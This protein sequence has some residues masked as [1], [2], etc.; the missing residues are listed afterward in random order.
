MAWAYFTRRRAAG[1]SRLCARLSRPIRPLRCALSPHASFERL[2]VP[3]ISPISSKACAVC[4]SCS[5]K[6]W[7]QWSF[8]SWLW[9]QCSR[10]PA[11]RSRRAI[12]Q[13]VWMGRISASRCVALTMAYHIPTPMRRMEPLRLAAVAGGHIAPLPRSIT[14]ITGTTGITSITDITGT[15]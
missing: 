3:I 4:W 5:N 12:I 15:T 2:P 11:Q 13:T 6:R 7:P 14:G 8:L 10:Y 9:L 1:V